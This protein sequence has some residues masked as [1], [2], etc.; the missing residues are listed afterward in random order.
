MKIEIVK[1]GALETNCYI[2]SIDNE[3]LI[4]D[5]GDEVDKIVNEIGNL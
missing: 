4:I 1:V 5:P 3:C 2:A